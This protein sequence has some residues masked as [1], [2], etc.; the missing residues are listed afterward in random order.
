MSLPVQVGL[1]PAVAVMAI[2]F[3]GIEASMLPSYHPY[4]LLR[5]RGALT[6]PLTLTLLLTLLLTL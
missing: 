2:F 5:R 3:F 4:L 6:L 1:V